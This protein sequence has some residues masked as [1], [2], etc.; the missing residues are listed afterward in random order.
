MD[1]RARTRSHLVLGAWLAAAPALA[2]CASTVPE[3]TA[4]PQRLS[5]LGYLNGEDLR[6]VCTKGSAERYRL[7]FNADYNQNI[8]TFDVTGDPDMSGARVEAR[9]IQATDIARVH[10]TDPLA[11]EHARV[12]KARMTAQQFALFALRLYE[13]GAFE[14]MPTNQQTSADGVYWLATGCRGGNWFFNVYPFPNDS[15]A[16]VRAKGRRAD[17]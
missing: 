1:S 17:G 2:G 6:A 4:A 11:P 13:S 8:R 9:V 3:G 15:F 14:P 12:E 16:D 7:V 5:W 10:Q